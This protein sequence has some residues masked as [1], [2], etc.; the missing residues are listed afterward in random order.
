MSNSTNRLHAAFIVMLLADITACGG[1]DGTSTY[2][3][4][5]TL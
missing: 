4:E 2:T 3:V 1:G 5:L